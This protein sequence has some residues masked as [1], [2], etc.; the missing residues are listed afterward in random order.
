MDPFLPLCFILMLKITI[1]STR[2]RVTASISGIQ[3][4]S[5]F[6]DWP[7][8][9]SP[10][11]QQSLPRLSPQPVPHVLC[12]GDEREPVNRRPAHDPPYQGAPRGR[13]QY[14]GTGEEPSCEACDGSKALDVLRF[15]L[16]YLSWVTWVSGI[17]YV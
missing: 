8:N 2:N 13:V 10:Q 11:Q 4:P 6:A 5:I 14:S 12:P 15:Y 9:V 1:W 17:A 16:D 7:G 3:R